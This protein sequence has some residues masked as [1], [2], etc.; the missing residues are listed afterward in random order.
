MG[1]ILSNLQTEQDTNVWLIGD[2][3]AGHVTAL[4]DKLS[5]VLAKVNM[6]TDRI[7]LMGDLAEC[8]T[9]TSVGAGLFETDLT[10]DQQIDRIVQ[11]FEP[12]RSIIDGVLIGNHEDRIYRTV[13]IDVAKRIAERLGVPYLRYQSIIRYNVG[14]QKYFFNVWHGGGGGGTTGNAINT[15]MKMANNTMADVYAMGH[16]HKLA[17]TSRHFSYPK[18]TNIERIKQH[19]VLTGSFLGYDDAY[20]EQMNLEQVVPGCPVVRLSANTKNTVVDLVHA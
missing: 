4:Y 10:P 5:A 13:G 2:I 9:R 11:I 20:P 19:F 12:Y 18:L 3:H 7:I 16:T 1:L 14:R 8:A 15:C 6:Q 17:T